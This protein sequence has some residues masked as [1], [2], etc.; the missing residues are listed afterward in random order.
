[1]Q[2]NQQQ[3]QYF[4]K[5]YKESKKMIIILLPLFILALGYELVRLQDLGFDIYRVLIYL[6]V[7]PFMVVSWCIKPIIN[8]FKSLK[9]IQSYYYNADNNCWQFTTLSNKTIETDKPVIESVGELK[10]FGDLFEVK[11]FEVG[12][13]KYYFP[14]DVANNTT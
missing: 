7:L 1:M 3:N 2:L 14:E 8:Y 10:Y 11:V 6:I 13:R 5:Q 4:H 9:I 12:G